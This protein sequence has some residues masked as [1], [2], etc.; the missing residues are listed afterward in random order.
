MRKFACMFI[1]I[2]CIFT[3]FF[4]TYCNYYC[5]PIDTKSYAYR[6]Y[7]NNYQDLYSI[8]QNRKI[9]YNGEIYDEFLLE[10]NVYLYLFYNIN[11]KT[12][13]RIEIVSKEN[14][15]NNKFRT[16][17]LLQIQALGGSLETLQMLINSKYETIVISNGFHFVLSSPN[18]L[19]IY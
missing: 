17:A 12:L 8:F 1:C 6:I 13:K 11:D 3:Y 5:F 19:I 4:Q 14:N 18:K 15:S 9:A 10:E 7:N 16:E 2:Y